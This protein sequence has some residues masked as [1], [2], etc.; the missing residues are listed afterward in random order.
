MQV[1]RPKSDGLSHAAALKERIVARTARVGVVGAGYIGLPLAVA[2]AKAGFTVVAV[3]QNPIRVAQLNQGSNYLRDVDDADL[4]AVVTRGKLTATTELDRIGDFDVVIMCV[5]TPV[6]LHKDPDTAFIRKIGAEIASRLR[7][8]RLITL[9]STSYP[10]VTEELLLPILATS[11]LKVGE[12]F[13]LAFSPERVD[14]GNARYVTVNTNKVVGGVTA[15]CLDVASTFYRQTIDEIV[16]VTSPQVAELSKVFENTFRAV[17]IALVNEMAQL[18]D[19]MG[20]NVWEVLDAASTKPFGMMRFNPGPGV[21]G[22]C[23]PLDPFYLT[24]KA[25]RYDFHMRFTETAAEINLAMPWFVREKLRRTLNERG[26]PLKDA[27]ILQIGLAYKR[28]VEDWQESPA[29]RVL[30]LLE[31]DGAIVEYHDPH[32][33]S[34]RE[35]D[36]RLRH[37]ALLTPDALSRATCVL[38]TTDHSSIDW[39]FVVR[40]ARVVLD[41]R[42]ATHHVEAGREKIVII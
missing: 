40:N 33:P 17:N 1:I 21:G 34:M 19:K 7:P 32:I 18:C 35:E 14:P 4:A 8:G 30:H 41:T 2:Q 27:R 26:T 11:G 12:D 13:F 23:I 29:L 24:W 5:P 38:I 3:D 39:D 28:D 16:P 10:G 22:H 42:N 15:A 31:D 36:G 6:T 37:S 25:R 20:I 9:E